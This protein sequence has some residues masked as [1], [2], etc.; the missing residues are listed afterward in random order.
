M[1]A[2]LFDIFEAGVVRGEVGIELI[3]CVLL[4]FREYVVSS[5]DVAHVQIMLF[6]LLVVKG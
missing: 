6:L 5:L 4:R 1:K 2:L 3:H